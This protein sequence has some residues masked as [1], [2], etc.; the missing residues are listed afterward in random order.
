M[1][2]WFLPLVPQVFARWTWATRLQDF[3]RQ[4]DQWLPRDPHMDNA[5]YASIMMITTLYWPKNCVISYLR[6]IRFWELVN[7]VGKNTIGWIFRRIYVL[8]G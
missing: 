5:G 1:I 7:I 8:I 6:K 3:E 4:L 2:E